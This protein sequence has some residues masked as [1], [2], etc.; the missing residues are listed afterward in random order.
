MPG[1]LVSE[2]KRW[3]IA[4]P[5]GELD[6]VFPSGAGNPE[7]HGNVLR[8]GFYPA[9]RRAGLRQVRFHDLRHCY[10]S[11]L[12]AN[13]EHPKRI[14]ALMGHSSIKVT[15]DIYGHLMRDINDG[16]AARLAD[17]ALGSKTVAETEEVAA[18]SLQVPDFVV[19]RDGIEPPTRGFS[20]LCSTN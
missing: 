18:E 16:V 9:L 5:L 12:I 2:L 1:A 10:A 11:L 15:F 8:R 14:Q 6:L 7:N 3:K 19:A 17:L 20:V 13:N 4:C